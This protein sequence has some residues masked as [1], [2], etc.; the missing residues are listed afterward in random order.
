ML[1]QRLRDRLAWLV[2][3]SLLLAFVF[4]ARA[5]MAASTLPLATHIAR[6]AGGGT[7]SE[8]PPTLP[9]VL[10]QGDVDAFAATL[11]DRQ[12]RELLIAALKERAQAAEPAEAEAGEGVSLS[13]ILGRLH[14]RHEMLEDKLAEA[15]VELQVLPEH[16]VVMLRNLTDQ[17]GWPAVGRSALILAALL[18]AGSVCEFLY[19][20]LTRG[21]CRKLAAIAMPS[22]GGRIGAALVHLMLDV[23]RLAVFSL[24][25]YAAS[26]LFFERFSPLRLLV[27]GVVIVVV[28]TR[29]TLALMRMF[30]RSPGADGHPLVP[31]PPADARWLTRWI[32]VVVG[33]AAFNLVNGEMLTILGLPAVLVNLT[34]VIIGS[35][36]AALAIALIGK[37]R[38]FFAGAERET[39]SSKDIAAAPVQPA[40]GERTLGSLVG[41]SWHVFAM[42]YV[43]ILWLVFAEGKLVGQE[44]IT[45]AAP[46]SLA[47]I[48]LAPFVDW[49]LREFLAERTRMQGTTSEAEAPGAL[50][51]LHGVI[52]NGVRL[53]FIVLALGLLAEGWGAG[54]ID[55]L[56]TPAGAAVGQGAL[57]ILL[58]IALAGVVWALVRR[59]TDHALAMETDSTAMPQDEHTVDD[60]AGS[61]VA[62]SRWQ[63]LIPLF[64]TTVL[65]VLITMV[66]MIILSSL[67]VNIGPLLAG[68]GVVGIAVGFGAQALVRDILSGIFFLIDD[69]FRLGEYIEISND[70]RGEVERISIRSM[71]LRHHRGPLLTLPFG[72][73]RSIVNHNRDWAIFK[74]EFRV[75]YDTD[76]NK[77]KKIIKKIGQELVDDPEFGP[78]I[79]E[80]LKSQGV[81]RIEESALI[82]RTKFKCKP[83]EQFVLRRVVFQKVK[84]AFAANGIML[85][86]RTVNVALPQGEHDAKTAALAAAAGGAVIA[87][88]QAAQGM[89][90]G[91]AGGHHG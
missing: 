72:E 89:A 5:S 85:A 62:K 11:T 26:F 88:Q 91:V 25:T 50:R 63:T 48:I 2:A 28:V 35:V 3:L 80:P 8:A 61:M 75:A 17:E 74:Q 30:L 86:H 15:G 82:V 76:L 37:Q 40:P 46:L 4:A 32:A 54:L 14:H 90:K 60:E 20:R 33:I 64:R 16:G 83:R 21:I 31:L 7:A 49:L 6:G 38:A 24:T 10:H 87:T 13:G 12:A 84:E 55:W 36:I 78:K 51:P 53:V 58:A 52:L 43:V 42:A 34:K 22:V 56:S 77:V 19:T 18:F 65:V 59:F 47:L 66:V 27:M 1:R 81:L 45:L 44:T 73:L 79:L 67:G 57:Q 68:A 23:L 41:S 9:D 69:A 71:Q 29:A 70:L 39:L